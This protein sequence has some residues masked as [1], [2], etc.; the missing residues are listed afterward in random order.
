MGMKQRQNYRKK[1]VTRL[2]RK[3]DALLEQLRREWDEMRRCARHESIVRAAVDGGIKVM[4]PLLALLAIGGVV[5]IAAVAPNVFAAV[6]KIGRRRLFMNE[7]DFRRCR[8]YFSR[9]NLAQFTGVGETTRMRIT[10]KGKRQVF[11]SAFDQMRLEKKQQWDGIWRIVIFDIPDKHKG[12]REG[13]RNQLRRFGMHC[14]QESVFV[15]PY[16]CERE[17]ELLIYAFSL[18]P[19]VRV[20]RTRE[21]FGDDD[22]RERFDIDAQC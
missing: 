16:P 8:Y 2:I 22:L 7:K 14:M 5:T 18:S 13:F 19:Y 10:E 15:A 4:R 20:I 3:P 1:L 12:E 21:L 6:G 11:R 17:V 9:R